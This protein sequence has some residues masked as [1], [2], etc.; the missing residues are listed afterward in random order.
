[1]KDKFK[2]V[3]VDYKYCDYLRLY[4]KRVCY[5]SGSKELR[6]YVGVL[7]EINECKYF[8]PLSS[9]KAKHIHMK[10]TLDFIRILNG[11]LGAINFNNMIPLKEGNYKLMDLKNISDNRDVKYKHL[12][13]LQLRWLN[14]NYYYIIGRAETLYKK[15][16][17]NKLDIKTRN[18][19]CNFSL[20]DEKC[21]EYN[22]N[23]LIL[24]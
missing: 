12:L 24:N 9:P 18:R 3:K 10:D 4:D 5:N 8:A 6:P 2:I 19:C 22:E 23:A 13:G 1:M 7:F 11:T 21:L 20:L 17:D 16:I 15:Y 14:R